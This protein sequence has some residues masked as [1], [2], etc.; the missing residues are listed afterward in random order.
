MSKK[1]FVKYHLLCQILVLC[2]VSFCTGCTGSS[3]F[4]RPAQNLMQPTEDMALVRFMRPSGFGFAINFNILDGEKVIGNS[5][6]KSQFDYFAEPGKHLF[7]ST[8]ENKVFLEANL[9]AGKTYYVL[10]RVYSGVWRARVAFVPVNRGSEYWDQVGDYENTLKITAPDRVALLRWQDANKLKIDKIILA[11]ETK[12]KQIE[13]WPKL[14]P[15][16]GR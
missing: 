4:M 7:I 12:W 15:D 9:E 3:A 5:V 16:D 1:Y 6:A 8:A 14:N 11:Y 13:T 2:L 10:L